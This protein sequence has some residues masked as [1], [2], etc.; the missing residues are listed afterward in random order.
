MSSITLPAL[1]KLTQARV[2]A[3]SARWTSS[4]LIGCSLRT[5]KTYGTGESAGLRHQVGTNPDKISQHSV[6]LFAFLLYF[7]VQKVFSIYASMAAPMITTINFV[8]NV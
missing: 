6:A 8:S 7:R 3:V 2:W 5:V 4:P 1:R